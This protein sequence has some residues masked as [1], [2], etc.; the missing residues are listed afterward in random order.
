MKNKRLQTIKKSEVFWSR[1]FAFVELRFIWP[2][3]LG[4]KLS[5]AP[6]SIFVN[7]SHG[8]LY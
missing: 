7:R 3:G 6:S 4:C 5:W 2:D 1:C 8:A